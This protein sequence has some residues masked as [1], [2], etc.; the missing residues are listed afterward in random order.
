[1][2]HPA[3]SPARPD[4]RDFPA[5]IRHAA[6]AWRTRADAGLAPAEQVALT[7]WL[8]ADARHREAYA[9]FEQ[10]WSALDR[11]HEAGATAALAAALD[12]HARRRRQRRQLVSAATLVIV[13]AAAGTAWRFFP[14]SS[15]PSST[16][17]VVATASRAVLLEPARQ[18]LPD[19]TVVELKEGADFSSEFTAEFRRV[20]LRRGE[21]HF[22][23]T[24][25]A[26]RPFVVVAAGVE[27]QAIGTAFAVQIGE[28]AVDVVVT[29][30]RVAL[31]P[32]APPAA[33]PSN[34]LP[35]TPAAARSPAPLAVLDASD[36]ARVELGHDAATEPPR[37]TVVRGD[38]VEERLAWRIPRVE[39][40]RTSLAEA[41]AI[42]NRH[43]AARRA[44][45][46]GE[47]D[48]AGDFVL[49]EAALGAVPVSGLFRVDRT[50]AFVSLLRDGFGIAAETQ[51]NGEIVLRRAGAER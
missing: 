46:S 9:R 21:A 51:P 22:Q 44:A 28:T 11:P 6:A 50:E 17:T 4:D 19:G 47:T 32:A 43:T 33:T 48:R 1:M 3:S 34:P 37:V 41:V 10:V 38:E 29:S 5:A 23:V 20:L 24:K 27:A 15:P 31:N 40:T 14:G 18:T 8:E 16:P 13:L 30:G 2:K 7:A 45:A 12:G 26:R 49:A 39:F 35:P 36:R 42:L 25:D